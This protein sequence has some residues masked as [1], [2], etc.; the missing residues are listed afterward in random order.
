MPGNGYRDQIA[1][2]LKGH[3]A[4]YIEIRL[5]ESQATRIR[6]RGRELEDIGSSASFGG[7]VRALVNDGWGFVSFNELDDLRSKVKLAIKQ[8]RV[9]GKD[10]TK[11]A[12]VAPVEDFVEPAVEKD[13][14]SFSLAEKK[15]N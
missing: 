13:A 15:F 10:A 11:F 1:E 6:Y 8:A 7:N 3:Q 14:S 12:P 5:E 2:S 4:D 9:A